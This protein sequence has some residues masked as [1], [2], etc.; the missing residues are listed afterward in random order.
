LVCTSVAYSALEV[1]ELVDQSWPP[2][3]WSGVDRIFPVST[4]Y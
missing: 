3:R 2:R 1:Y 4:N